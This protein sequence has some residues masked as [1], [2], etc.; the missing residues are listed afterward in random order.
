MLG[1]GADPA[2]VADS[3]R[4]MASARL[5]FA[6]ACN[7]AR[8]M[9]AYRV[10]SFTFRCVVPSRSSHVVN[11]VRAAAASSSTRNRRASTSSATSGAITSS[12]RRP[13]ARSCSASSRSASVSITFSTRTRSP[14]S[15]SA[16]NRFS[17]DTTT[18]ACAA[19]M[20]PANN[21]EPVA[22]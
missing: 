1:D 21:A 9:S 6:I 11:H 22:A 16:G 5:G 17:D 15:R 12:N 2:E 10:D 8:S 7:A 19:S 3:V 14:T 18:S 20:S 4:Q 13:T